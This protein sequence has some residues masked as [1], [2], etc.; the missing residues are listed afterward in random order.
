M[1]SDRG[2][3][4][5]KTRPP[6]GTNG[7]DSMRVPRQVELEAAYETP[8]ERYA[9]E[10][11]LVAGCLYGSK[12]QTKNVTRK[13]KVVAEQVKDAAGN[14]ILLIKCGKVCDPGQKFCPRHAMMDQMKRGETRD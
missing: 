12:F 14:P 11:L 2:E 4:A 10:G 6:G 7:M 3:T 8:I 1:L 5:R 13:G 9:R